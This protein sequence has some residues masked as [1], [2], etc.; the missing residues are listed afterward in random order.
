[1]KKVLIVQGNPVEHSYGWAL[2]D[3]YAEGA[4]A[5]GAEVRMIRLA[6][7][8]FNPNLSGGY[9]NKLPLEDD[10]VKAQE[11]IR[12][13]EH[14]VFTYPIW[15]GGPPA[16][17]KGFLDRVFLPG[18]AFKYKKGS[19][20]PD[21]LLKGR[22]ARLIVTMDSPL[23]YYRLVQGQPGHR[24]MKVSTLQFCGIRPVKVTSIGQVGKLTDPEREHWLVRVNRLG[25]ALA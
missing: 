8:D 21:Q 9:K 10:L 5:A 25:Q 1:M 22:T 24:M 11:S 13:A 17:L 14:L 7:L 19:S 18:Y 2:G 3:S 4:A 12:W 20:L 23:W 16:L 15:W 6:E